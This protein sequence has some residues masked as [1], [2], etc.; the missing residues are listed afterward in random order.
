MGVTNFV[1]VNN[2]CIY[3]EKIER[4]SMREKVRDQRKTGINIGGRGNEEERI[5]R[6]N[7]RRKKMLKGKKRN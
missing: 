4:K 1:E 7:E 3:G 5:K 2:I 6:G